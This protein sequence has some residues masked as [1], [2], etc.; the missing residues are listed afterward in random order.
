MSSSL[1]SPETLERY[2]NS[3]HAEWAC[4]DLEPLSGGVANLTCRGTLESN[5]NS[6]IVKHAEEL[7]GDGWSF[8]ASRA[9]DEAMLLSRLHDDQI[10]VQE[11]YGV[12]VSTPKLLAY[13][14]DSHT[15]IIEDVEAI[16]LKTY[17]LSNPIDDSSAWAIGQAIGVSCSPSESIKFHGCVVLSSADRCP[18]YL[19]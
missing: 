10:C 12:K 13:L 1:L 16:D 3:S 19:D 18:R 8:P 9:Q 15:Q 4:S 7:S 11:S 17:L 6:I 2:L 14:D 5:D